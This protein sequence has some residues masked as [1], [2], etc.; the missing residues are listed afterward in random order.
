MS[1]K[2]LKL[3]SYIYMILPIIIF[4]LGFIKNIYS[5]PMTIGLLI[6]LFFLY[7]Q[8]KNENEIFIETKS[9]ISIFIAITILCI[10]AGQGNFFYQSN[11]YN[12]RNAIFRDLIQNKWPVY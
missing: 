6:I 3:I 1:K 10:L 5:I 11:D 2:N 12:A 7:K 9:V 4:I 8:I